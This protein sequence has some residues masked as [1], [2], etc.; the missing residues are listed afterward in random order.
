MDTHGWVYNFQQMD[1]VNLPRVLPDYRFS[2][3]HHQIGQ[4]YGAACK[5]LIERN[6][7]LSMQRLQRHTRA[8]RQQVLE[9]TLQYR[10]YLL[11]YAPFL[12]E[13]IQGMAGGAGISL[14]EAYFLQ[15]RAEIQAHLINSGHAGTGLE[16]TTFALSGA[17]TGD[18]HPLAGQNADLPAFYADLCVVAEI[19][20]EDQPAVLM[21]TPAGQVSYIGMNES[22]L[23][24]FAN[25]LVCE[26]WRVGFPR[27]C[28]SRLALTQDTVGDAERILMVVP[29]AASRNVLLLDAQGNMLDLEFAVQRHGHLESTEGWIGHTNHFISSETLNEERASPE[30]L[31]NSQQRLIRLQRLIQS[32]LGSLDAESMQS[33]LRDRET[34]PHPLCI[35]P[36]DP[37]QGDEMTVTSV[38]AEPG[39]RRIRA[40]VGPPSRNPYK[41][42]TFSV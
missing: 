5:R 24:V 19:L 11:Q 34:F 21:V 36:G 12:D 32:R 16:C 42:F 27:Y 23:C 3:S 31:Y 2:G 28:F 30:E 4:Q 7:E 1:E 26:G 14:E 35:E 38:I 15:L 22:G 33:Y 37:G 18:H 29:R 6:L 25:Y 41:S 8:F 17:C 9:L 20:P 13:E 39:R 40:A 10:P